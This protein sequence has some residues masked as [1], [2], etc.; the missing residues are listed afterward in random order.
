[1]LTM[2]AEM[3]PNEDRLIISLGTGVQ[4]PS[5]VTGNAANLI[6]TLAKLLTECEYRNQMFRQD[7]KEDLVSRGRHYRFNVRQG[8][9]SLGLEEHEAAGDI[10]EFTHK[11][12]EDDDVLNDITF[13][14]LAMREGGQRLNIRS[15]AEQAELEARFRE[16]Q[17]SRMFS[18]CC[19][20][21][22]KG[23]E[24]A[25]YQSAVYTF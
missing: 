6:K 15:Q 13:C 25:S 4:P 21:C 18:T 8:L 20:H 16:Y 9:G 1:M 19:V 17:I 14:A 24:P 7:H 3:F 10:A 22:L 23:W 11:Y 2:L 12:L 5:K